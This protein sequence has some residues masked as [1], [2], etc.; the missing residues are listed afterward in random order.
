MTAGLGG[1]G[2]A[3]PLAVTLN[4][5]AA[6]CI[7]CDPARAQRRLATRYLDVLADTLDE[8]IDLALAAKRRADA[9]C[10]SR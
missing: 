2:G 5:G 1:M 8:G 10:P 4:G 6:L 3:Q 9:R 7:E